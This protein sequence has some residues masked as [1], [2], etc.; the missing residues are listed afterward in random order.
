MFFNIKYMSRSAMIAALYAALTLALAPISFSAMQFRVS[1]AFTVLP[2]F[3]PEAIPG[4]A[5]GCLVANLISGATVMDVVFGSIATLLA[6]IATRHL[7]RR[8]LFALAMPA[9]FNALIIGPVVY[10]S[11]MMGDGAFSA[12]ALGLTCISVG[13][14]ELG[15][16]YTLGLGLARIMRRLSITAK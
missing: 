13:A 1:E 2:L 8:P 12:A 7:L 6:A 11:Y 16:V 15:V 3:M 5:I 14:G 4:L 9:V 10:F